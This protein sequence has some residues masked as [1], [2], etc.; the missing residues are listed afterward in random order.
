MKLMS[1]FIRRYIEQN[2]TGDAVLTMQK[3][4]TISN[5][6]LIVGWANYGLI[7]RSKYFICHC[8]KV[9]G[10]WKHRLLRLEAANQA[11][12]CSRCQSQRESA[13]WM[14]TST[15][16]V[17][18]GAQCLGNGQSYQG[19]QRLQ[20]RLCQGVWWFHNLYLNFNT[21]YKQLFC[22]II[23]WYFIMCVYFYFDRFCLKSLMLVSKAWTCPNSLS[24]MRTHS[25]NL[26]IFKTRVPTKFWPRLSTSWTKCNYKHNYTIKK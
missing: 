25:R 4:I 22:L 24:I 11:N 23:K 20:N 14:Q 6:K 10:E 18:V 9:P 1:P 7:V 19:L 8:L 3:C 26:E 5:F 21:N 16:K 2:R 13:V 15:A 17:R 12:W